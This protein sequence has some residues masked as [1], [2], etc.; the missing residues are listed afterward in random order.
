M[1]TDVFGADQCAYHDDVG[2]IVIDRSRW[3]EKY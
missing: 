3:Q 2:Y 1:I